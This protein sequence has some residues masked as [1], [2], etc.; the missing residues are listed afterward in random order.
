MMRNFGNEKRA[1][2]HINKASCP[3]SLCQGFMLHIAKGCRHAYGMAI[4]V[5]AYQH[6]RAYL[7]KE[8]FRLLQGERQPAQDGLGDAQQVI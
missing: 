4:C 7:H 2:R 8:V 3:A 1:I 5:S 6:S